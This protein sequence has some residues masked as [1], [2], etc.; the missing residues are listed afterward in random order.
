M[1]P[2]RPK[3]DTPGWGDYLRTLGRLTGAVAFCTAVYG[4]AGTGLYALYNGVTFTRTYEGRAEHSFKDGTHRRVDGR[5]FSLTNPFKVAATEKWELGEQTAYF[6]SAIK[7]QDRFAAH[8]ELSYVAPETASA[9]KQIRVNAKTAGDK[10]LTQIFQQNG[11]TSYAAVDPLTQPKN[12]AMI[13]E[14]LSKSIVASI[15][16]DFAERV[17][18][19]GCEIKVKIPFKGYTAKV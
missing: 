2:V 1:T 18:V 14:A 17:T 13:C 10:T 3:E 4:A 19:T 6:H 8:V 5:G 9:D 12:A 15:T 16:P 7:E 11:W